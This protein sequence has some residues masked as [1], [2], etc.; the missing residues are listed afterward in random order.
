MPFVKRI[1]E[2]LNNALSHDPAARNRL[3]VA[4]AYP[5]VHAIWGYRISHFLWNHQL[6]L[7]ARIYSNLVRSATGIEIHPAAKIGRRCFIDHGMGVVIGATSVI[8]DDVM[9]YHDVTLGA[10]GIEKGN[11]HP[12]IENNVIIGAGARLLGNITIGEGSR[13]SANAVITKDLAP[14]T[15][16]DQADFFVI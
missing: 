4:L 8:G 11:R 2:D 16:L 6:K 9:M 10:R 3:E 14:R 12:T 7:V 1:F 5:G 15:L 13:I